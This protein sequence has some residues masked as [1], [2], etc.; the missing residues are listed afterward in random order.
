VLSVQFEKTCDLLIHK[1]G[2][3]FATQA[4]Y[5][6]DDIATEVHVKIAVEKILSRS[7]ENVSHDSK[8]CTWSAMVEVNPRNQNVITVANEFFSNFQS[9]I[10]DSGR[11]FD[12]VTINGTKMIYGLN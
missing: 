7:K 10:N 5:V 8:F 9:E 1:E 11:V 3:S 2:S 12:K 6:L 4:I